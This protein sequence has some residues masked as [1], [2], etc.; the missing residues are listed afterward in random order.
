MRIILHRH[1]RD[2]G[3]II[4][5]DLCVG[6]NKRYHHHLDVF[7]VLDFS[8]GHASTDR[9][10]H[11]P[12]LDKREL[13]VC[14]GYTG[15]ML[16]KRISEALTCTSCD[17]CFVLDLAFAQTPKHLSPTMSQF[18]RALVASLALFCAPS[19]VCAFQQIV[20]S[21]HSVVSDF[22]FRWLAGKNLFQR[23][24]RRGLGKSMG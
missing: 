23:N 5:A 15:A 24:I 16:V 11:L 19:S 9:L 17:T 3:M 18:V 22:P 7:V 20:L 12:L 1:F 13:A 8:G 2:K 21:S 10:S 4:L 14:A 6:K